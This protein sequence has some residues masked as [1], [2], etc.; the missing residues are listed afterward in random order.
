[1]FAAAHNDTAVP[2]A[3]KRTPQNPSGPRMRSRSLRDARAA[4]FSR[5]RMLSELSSQP[6]LAAR[7]SAY[8]ECG[9]WSGAGD[10]SFVA[11]GAEAAGSTGR[12][13]DGIG[14]ASDAPRSRAF[15]LK[16]MRARHAMAFAA[17]LAGTLF[18]FGNADDFYEPCPDFPPLASAAEVRRNA[19]LQTALEEVEAR[20]RNISTSLPSGL[21]ATVVYDQTVRCVVLCVLWRCVVDEKSLWQR[22]RRSGV[23]AVGVWQVLWRS[24]FGLRDAFNAS[25]GRWR[26]K[27]RFWAPADAVAPPCSTPTTPRITHDG[28]PQTPQLS[29]LH[30]VQA[31][32]APATSSASQVSRRPAAV[33]RH[34]GAPLGACLTVLNSKVLSQGFHTHVWFRPSQTSSSSSCATPAWSLSTSR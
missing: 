24:G 32:R 34:V 17:L 29:Q 23:L 5:S 31:R 19:G 25:S 16:K 11:P 28:R 3:V 20:L 22:E 6:R 21:V 33:G 4:L 13:C 18:S 2:E 15:P 8:D 7:R 1:M 9:G 10:A 27:E 26:E 14:K 30:S 12:R